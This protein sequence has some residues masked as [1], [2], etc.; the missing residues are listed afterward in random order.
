MKMPIHF[1]NTKAVLK[2]GFCVLSDCVFRYFYYYLN[3]LIH[4]TER[5]KLVWAVEVMASGKNVGAGKPHKGKPGSVCAA[6]Y[7]LYN[8]RYAA[9][10]H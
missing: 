8:G 10:P 1:L 5:N 3:C 7:W 4:G 2:D 9:L 6:P